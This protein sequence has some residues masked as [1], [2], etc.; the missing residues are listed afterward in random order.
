MRLPLDSGLAKK[1]ES[2]PREP[3][4]AEPEPANA[5]GRPIRESRSGTGS[6]LSEIGSGPR[7]QART[8]QGRC[9][10][11]YHPGLVSSRGHGEYA[12]D[13]ISTWFGMRVEQ[14]VKRGISCNE[15]WKQTAS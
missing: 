5:G 2:T 15:Q 13:I 12:S 14:E 11:G 7:Q 10:S 6:R 8:P 3:C 9:Y 4:V 1:Q